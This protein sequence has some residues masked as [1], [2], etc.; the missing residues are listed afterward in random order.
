MGYMNEL[1]KPP[2]VAPRTEMPTLEDLG[3]KLK[4]QRRD[5]GFSWFL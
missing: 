4:P 2:D 5:R 3:S 1:Q